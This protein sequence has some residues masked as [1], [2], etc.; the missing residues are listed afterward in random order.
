[1]VI[2]HMPVDYAKHLIECNCVLPQ[3]KYQTPLVYHRF[4]VFSVVG[5]DALVIPSYAQCPNCGIV[6]RVMEVGKSVIMRREELNSLLTEDEIAKS[7]PTSL[8]DILRQYKVDYASWQQAKFIIENEL[9]GRRITLSREELE[10]TVMGKIL[11]IIGHTL[12]T[13]ERYE[14]GS[15]EVG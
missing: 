5:E 14:K 11:I 6:H 4:V 7:L 12:W 13:V 1:M 8:A 9:W 3:F 2:P 15:N 10:G